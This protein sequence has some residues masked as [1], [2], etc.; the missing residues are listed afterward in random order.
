M[1]LLA[2]FNVRLEPST[3]GLVGA[4]DTGT[5]ARGLFY[6]LIGSTD[7]ALSQAV[8]EAN[9]P[10]PFTCSALIGRLERDG[11][12]R[13][14]L[15]SG[16]YG[17]RFTTLTQ[18]VTDALSAA[19]YQRY[20]TG[21]PTSLGPLQFRIRRVVTA[22]EEDYWGRAARYEDLLACPPRSLWRLSF[23]SP[24]AF[25]QQTGHLPLPVPTCVFRSALERWNA[26]GPASLRLNDDLEARLAEA[27]FPSFVDVESRKVTRRQGRFVGFCGRVDFEAIRKLPQEQLSAL[28]ALAEFLYFSGAGHG[29]PRGW[30]QVSVLDSALG[31]TPGQ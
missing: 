3:P 17:L 6:D 19:L 27:V 8:H 29:T 26:F 23:R 24:T 28:T 30:G 13:M 20:A 1:S 12:G 31:A 18:A 4:E 15:G 9:G 2:S 14:L 21:E 16:P 25:R 5:Q 10:K 7:P 11:E 22:S